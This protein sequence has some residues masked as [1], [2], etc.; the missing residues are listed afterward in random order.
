MAAWYEQ[1]TGVRIIGEEVAEVRDALEEEKEDLQNQIMKI[2][3]EREKNS[4]I[5]KQLSQYAQQYE[6]KKEEYALISNLS[7]TA[8][9]GLSQSSRMDF[10][11]Y[12][13]R[14]YFEQIVEYANQRLIQ[15]SSGQFLLQCRRLEDLKNQGK[16][17]L[18]LD[19]YSLATDSIRDVKSLSGGESFMAALS[20]ALGLADVIQN[21]A[22]AIRLETMFIDEG[23][24]AL[25]DT[26]REQAV[27]ILQELAGDQKI[28]GIISHVAELKEQISPKL[29]VEKTPR[30]SKVHWA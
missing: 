3:H 18:D 12:V 13:Q 16:V 24:G 8:N 27:R 5:Q 25:D 9:G 1:M 29:V 6:K 2:Y 7:K 10:E 19:V 30:G 14:Q 11:S 20:M 28:V 15:M 22:G 21:T 26:A 4:Q 23:F 17:G